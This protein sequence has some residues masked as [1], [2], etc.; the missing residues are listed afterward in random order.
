MIE[1]LDEIRS[2]WSI[3]HVIITLGGPHGAICS[4]P[5]GFLRVLVPKLPVVNTVG[6]GDAF[7]A[8]ICVGHERNLPAKEFIRLGAAAASAKL[9]AKDAGT[10]DP[11][12]VRRLVGEVQVEDIGQ[13][14]G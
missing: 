2:R 6:C 7:V 13:M 1:A 9:G 10:C 4:I 3:D 8:G 14:G 12:E 5:T 11:E